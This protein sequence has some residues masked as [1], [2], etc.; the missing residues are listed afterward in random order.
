MAG[1]IILGVDYLSQPC[2]TNGHKRGH[3]SL[4]ACLYAGE[5]LNTMEEIY[6]S[7]EQRTTIRKDDSVS[8]RLQPAL[9]L[10]KFYFC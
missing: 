4:G 5:C 7:F 8:G 6:T 1:E 9:S 3:E 10:P 2:V